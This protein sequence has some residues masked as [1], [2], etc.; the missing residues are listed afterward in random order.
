MIMY[1][2]IFIIG[3]GVGFYLI[4][5]TKIILNGLEKYKR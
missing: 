3:I 2:I 1:V 4:P 5:I